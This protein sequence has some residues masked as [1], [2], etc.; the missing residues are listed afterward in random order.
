M[1]N[2][3]FIKLK[4]TDND[5]AQWFSYLFCGGVNLFDDD[6]FSDFNRKINAAIW[7]CMETRTDFNNVEY[8]H[9]VNAF[10]H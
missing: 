4:A 3:E 2:W 1:T 6:T 5:I 10:Y 9:F 7:G 8:V